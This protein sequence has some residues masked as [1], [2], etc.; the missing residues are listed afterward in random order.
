MSKSREAL[1][2]TG[3]PLLLPF[4][5]E[6]SDSA[7]L[8]QIDVAPAI[9]EAVLSERHQFIVVPGHEVPTIEEIVEDHSTFLVVEKIGEARAQIDKDHPQDLRSISL[10]LI[11][12]AS[13]TRA[14]AT[15]S[16]PVSRFQTVAQLPEQTAR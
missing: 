5:C 1:S 9:Y 2:C 3:S 16:A 12:L 14:R 11:S 15:T 8:E 13:P 7:C 4:H 6:C 10:A